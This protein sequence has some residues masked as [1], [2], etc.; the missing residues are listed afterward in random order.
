MQTNAEKINENAANIEKIAITETFS[1]GDKVKDMYRALI[2]YK[3]FTFNKLFTLKKHSKNEV[4]T[5]FTGLLEMSRRNKVVT[6]QD[7][8]SQNF[9]KNK[10]KIKKEK[11][12]KNNIITFKK[13][14][15]DIVFS[16]YISNIY[17]FDNCNTYK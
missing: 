1:V 16:F 14:V 9:T 6:E 4:V 10:L 17:D 8:K 5:A 2:K 3:K 15:D 11:I 13:R 12:G 7:E